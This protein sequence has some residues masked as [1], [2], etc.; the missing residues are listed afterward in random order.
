MLIV[1]GHFVLEINGMV[2]N[3]SIDFLG[4]DHP[5]VFLATR[6]SYMLFY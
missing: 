2:Q 6:S 5:D 3:I 1:T 4:N